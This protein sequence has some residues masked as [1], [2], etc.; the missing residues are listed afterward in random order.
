MSDHDDLAR[1]LS[2]LG[3][4]PVPSDLRAQHLHAMRQAA[5]GSQPTAPARRPFGRVAVAAAALVGFLV[6]STGFAMAGAL[7]GPVQGVAHDVLSVV[8]V[9]VPDWRNRG[10]CVSAAARAG[11]EAAKAACP[12][13]GR[14][15]GAPGRDHTPGSDGAPGTKGKPTKPGK[16]AGPNSDGDPCTGK[17]PWAG[18]K[19]A[20]EKAAA[21]ATCPDRAADGQDDP[22]D[23]EL[24]EEQAPPATE[25]EQPP[26]S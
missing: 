20:E 3:D 10:E 26:G 18:R 21:K 25:G 8:Q 13:G 12:K 22:V 19:T 6:G 4:Q 1:R 5:D 17:P 24:E 11:D 23:D 16:A 9:D 2:G 7:P 15:E 14:P